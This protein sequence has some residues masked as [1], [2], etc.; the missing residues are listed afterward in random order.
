M[1]GSD[2]PVRRD[3]GYSGSIESLDL[4]QGRFRRCWPTGLV[5]LVDPPFA[6]LTPAEAALALAR[7]AGERGARDAV[8]G[9]WETGLCPFRSHSTVTLF[10]R[11][12]G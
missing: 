11:L 6:R 1:R 12:R 10:A 4:I 9:A 8:G 3:D 7:D 5:G 2:G